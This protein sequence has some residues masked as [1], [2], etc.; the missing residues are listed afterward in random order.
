MEKTRYP[1]IPHLPFSQ[2][3]QS[4]DSYISNIDYLKNADTIIVTEKMDGENTSM[5]RDDIHARSINAHAH[6]SRTWVRRFHGMFAHHIPENMRIIGENVFAK[7]SIEYFGLS[8]YFFVFAIWIDNTVLSW[9]DTLDWIDL[10]NSYLEQEIPDNKAFRLKTVPAFY[11]G[12]WDDN[13]FKNIISTTS[14][15]GG[16]PKEGFVVR[17]ADSFQVSEYPL[18][19]AKWVRANHVQTDKHWLTQKIVEN[20]LEEE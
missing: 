1:S 17:D 16:S 11:V 18:R 9:V 4:D 5:Y 20:H 6:E 14:F 13:V 19:A 2:S 8:S 12:A 15:F 3:L 7:H 10:F